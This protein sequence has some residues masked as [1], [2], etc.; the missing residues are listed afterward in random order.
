LT[1]VGHSRDTARVRVDVMAT[2][3]EAIARGVAALDAMMCN[4][5]YRPVLAAVFMA[6]GLRGGVRDGGARVNLFAVDTAFGD[7]LQ[8]YGRE[9][10]ARLAPLDAVSPDA[11]LRLEEAIADAIASTR[12]RF[13]IALAGLL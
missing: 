3:D 7:V 13:V 8:A 12:E 11:A 2:Y 6:A 5:D 4:G 1:L 9:L 10:A